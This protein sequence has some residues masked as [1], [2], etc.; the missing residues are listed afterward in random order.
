[1]LE[2]IEASMECAL[3]DNMYKTKKYI[4]TDQIFNVFMNIPFE[5]I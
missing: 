3:F 4:S 2:E 1:M 5:S